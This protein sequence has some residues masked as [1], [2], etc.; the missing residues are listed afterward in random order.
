MYD[1]AATDAQLLF[2]QK[3]EPNLDFFSLSAY[4][5][6]KTFEVSNTFPKRCINEE[7]ATSIKA[8]NSSFLT[9]WP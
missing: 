9:P 6:C 2:Y 7:K 1:A 5:V 8:K 3:L 4:E